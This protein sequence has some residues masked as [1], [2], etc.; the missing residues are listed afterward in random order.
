MIPNI[1]LVPIAEQRFTTLGDWYQNEDGS[2]TIAISK[3][4]DWRHEFLVL[5]HELTEWSICRATGVSSQEAD[6]FDR[7]WESDIKFGL[8]SIETEAGFS[9]DCPYRRGHIWGA[10]MERLFCWL[11]GASWKDYERACN[12]LLGEYALAH[13]H[14]NAIV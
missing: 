3:M 7:Y 14:P 12:K 6:V 2:F 11:L 13:G 1:L 8:V 9:K 4:L 10:R 5:I